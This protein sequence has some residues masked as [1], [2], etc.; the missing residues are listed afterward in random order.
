LTLLAPARS[1]GIWCSLTG[2]PWIFGLFVFLDGNGQPE[3]AT[4]VINGGITN[5]GVLRS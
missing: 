1:G 2:G 5:E 3:S 4:A